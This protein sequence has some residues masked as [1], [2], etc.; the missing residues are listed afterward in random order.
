MTG[1]AAKADWM[2]SGARKF[3]GLLSLPKKRTIA[4]SECLPKLLEK[5]ERFEKNLFWCKIGAAAFAILVAFGAISTDSLGI[6]TLFGA[7]VGAAF[8]IS[9]A[10]FTYCPDFSAEK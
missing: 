5:R 2:I 7:V 1:T 6:W 3:R 10:F 4:C 8:V 9:L